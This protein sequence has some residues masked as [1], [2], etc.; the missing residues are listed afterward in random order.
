VSSIDVLT[1]R[2]RIETA[3]SGEIGNY[4]W[5]NGITTPAV[6]VESGIV[7][8][9]VQPQKVTGLEVTIEPYTDPSLRIYLGN[10]TALDDVYRIL[11]KQWDI[12][13]SVS[14]AV[15]TLV[16]ALQDCL[17]GIEPLLPRS[18]ALDSLEQQALLIE[19]QRR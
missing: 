4:V 10:Q 7:Q 2:D 13:K 15:N 3:L 11:L 5:Q 14:S 18:T 1:L 9:S 6:K 19:Y 8:R 16:L 17:S 12:T